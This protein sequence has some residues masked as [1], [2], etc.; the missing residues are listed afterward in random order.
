M[1][2]TV[3][4]TPPTPPDLVSRAPCIAPFGG[5]RDQPGRLHPLVP[6]LLGLTGRE[7]PRVAFLPTATGDS[8]DSIQL[9]HSRVPEELAE[10]SHLALFG[11]TVRD[12]ESFLLAQ[13]LIWV[14]GG[15][16]VNLLAIW[17]AH[18]VDRA[19]RAAWEA[20]VVLT[21]G[22]A[23]SLCWF[24]G[25]TTDSFD[26]A[27]LAPLTDGLGFLPGS[28]CPH[29]DGEAQRR[30]LY[31]HLVGAGTL[32]P[33]YALDDDAALVFRGRTVREVVTAR[34]GATAYRVTPDGVG[35]AVEQALPARLLPA[36][37]A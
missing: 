3:T 20:G 26:L 2:S 32:P 14:G 1:P 18:G 5:L 4:C 37:E 29:Y 25:G 16:T 27:E 33:G 30:P 19:L 15:N 23:G 13:D 8:A 11:R 36:P 9:F 22:S 21:G 28:H 35:A 12:V 24:E 31:Q 6:F 17:R 7:R 34:E 10:R